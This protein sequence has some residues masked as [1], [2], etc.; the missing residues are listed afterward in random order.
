MKNITKISILACTSALLAPLN[1]NAESMKDQHNYSKTNVNRDINAQSSIDNEDLETL[2]GKI[3]TLE[4]FFAMADESGEY[5]LSLKSSDSQTVDSHSFRGPDSVRE[6]AGVTE[7]DKSMK[8]AGNS[9]SQRVDN[10]NYRGPDSTQETAGITP[11]QKDMQSKQWHDQNKSHYSSSQTSVQQGQTLVL[12]TNDD[13]YGVIDLEDAY[14]LVNDQNQLEN[15]LVFNSIRNQ[16]KNAW[17]QSDAKDWQ[18]KSDRY[19]REPS[20]RESALDERQPVRGEKDQADSVQQ[21]GVTDYSQGRTHS[22]VG[23]QANISKNAKFEVTGKV[24][25]K[26]G[27]QGILVSSIEQIYEVDAE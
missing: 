17:T 15:N 13:L 11:D 9:D 19:Q 12:L 8:M 26:A 18:A 16:G 5:S 27:I 3:V 24:I 10:H 25:E 22:N 4:E 1:M 7:E 2:K 21:H 6:T 23:A 14:I 20:E